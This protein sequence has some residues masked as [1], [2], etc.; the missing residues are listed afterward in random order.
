M[1]L[2]VLLH[3]EVVARVGRTPAGTCEL[4]Y[5]PSLRHKHGDVQTPLSLAFPINGQRFTGDKVE[6][7]L[8]SLLPEND[9]A[10]A[11]AAAIY[12]ANTRDPLSLLTAIGK[13]CAGAI[14]L[15][16]ADEVEKVRADDGELVPASDADIEHRLA[17]LKMRNELSWVMPGEHWSLPGMQ[18][19]FGLRRHASQWWWAHGSQPTTHIVKPGVRDAQ[20]QALIEHVSMRASALLG[21]P[22]A[23]TTFTDFKSERAIVVERFDRSPGPDGALQ[24][25][26]QEDLCQALGTAQ[27]HESY[28]GPTAVEIV[29]FLR[30]ASASA[31]QARDNVAAF[32]D[33]LIFNSII[34]APDA[35]ARNYSIHLS[36][37]N[38]ELS[39]LYDVASGWAYDAPPGRERTLSMSIGGE[40]NPE[41]I[42]HQHWRVFA[43]SARLDD[44][45]VVE[46]VKAIAA[47]TPQ[48]FETALAELGGTDWDGQVTAVSRRLLPNLERAVGVW[49]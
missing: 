4:V 13:D 38:V 28:G 35:H 23:A 9:S 14:Q 40:F 42:E 20:H 48:A 18:E 10:R 19:K 11:E 43:Q 39:P 30:D 24:R 36:G 21:L 29:Q 41:A 3:G 8:W 37:D 32:V 17:E 34:A 45:A 26:H 44:V 33:G 25:R 22:T 46:R 31:G 1:S 47:G 2:T 27:K 16:L 6:T 12:G 49:S 5:A 7:F 15:C